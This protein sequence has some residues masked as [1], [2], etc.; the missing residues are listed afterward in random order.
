MNGIGKI[1]AF[2]KRKE[3]KKLSNGSANCCIE[4]MKEQNYFSNCSIECCIEKKEISEDVGSA[5]VS[6][7]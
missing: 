7:P 2:K 4:K 5:Y 1:V 3:E 6:S